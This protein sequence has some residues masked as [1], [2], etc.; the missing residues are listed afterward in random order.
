MTELRTTEQRKAD[1][2]AVLER[3]GHAWLATASGGVPHT[4]AVTVV[5]DC[6]TILIA[7]REPT[8]TARNLAAN[9]AAR[10][11]IGTP[12]DCIMIDAEVVGDAAATADAAD[13]SAF[14][15]AAGW[16][17]ADEGPDWRYYRLR[18]R[19][20]EAYRGYGELEGRVVMRAGEWLA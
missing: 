10:L 16:D 13:R 18:P 20:I 5:W 9:R 6:A 17:P 3:Q 2:L 12:D 4:I 8:P 14:V 19:R 1:V 11:T 7:T 15:G